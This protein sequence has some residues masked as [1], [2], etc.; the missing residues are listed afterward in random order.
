[1]VQKTVRLILS[2]IAENQGLVSSW[3]VAMPR[4]MPE[5]RKKISGEPVMSC[6]RR[7]VSDFM[8]AQGMVETGDETNVI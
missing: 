6:W 3:I 5:I 2:D 8:V 7:M 4:E 1:M